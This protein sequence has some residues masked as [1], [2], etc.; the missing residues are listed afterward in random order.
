VCPPVVQQEV[1]A[2]RE[3]GGERIDEEWAQIGV[4]MGQ[5][6]AEP[7]ARG[8]RHGA[9]DGPPLEARLA[10]SPWVRAPGCE[11][12]PDDGQEAEAAVILAEAPDGASV[13]RWAHPLEVVLTGGLER[14]NGL[15]ML[16][17]GAAGPRCAPPCSAHTPACRASCP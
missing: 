10:C 13:R 11:A 6:E 9:I 16:W 5:F 2:I 1:Q 3:C 7:G 8:R 17:C 4:H 12:A 15:R 14:R